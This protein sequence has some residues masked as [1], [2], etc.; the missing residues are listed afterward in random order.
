MAAANLLLLIPKDETF[1]TT[2]VVLVMVSLLFTFLGNLM[3]NIKPNYFIGIRLPSTLEKKKTGNNSSSRRN[4]VV[5]WRNSLC[6]VGIVTSAKS[7]VPDLGS[8]YDKVL[9]GLNAQLLNSDHDSLM[10]DSTNSMAV[11]N[12]SSPAMS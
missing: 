6:I 2:K 10:F 8:D 7:D 3:Y 11:P 4:F 5:R 1:N 9:L 12:P